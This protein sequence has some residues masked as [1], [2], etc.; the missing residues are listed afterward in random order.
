MPTPWLLSNS[1]IDPSLPSGYGTGAL[2][3]NVSS[4]PAWY[5][6]G[7]LLTAPTDT[8]ATS[9]LSATQRASMLMTTFGAVG[10][11]IGSFFAAE[12]QRNQLKMQ[13][14]NAKFASQMSAINARGSE[15]M[16]Q[17][18]INA[19]HQAIGRYTMQAGQA[20]ASAETALAGRGIELG[21]GSAKEVIGSMDLIKEIDRMTM[22][23]N[24]VRQ[25]EAYRMQAFNQRTQSVME[26]LT[27]RNLLT[28]A[29]GISSP[30]AGFSSLMGSGSTWWQTRL[31]G[32]ERQEMLDAMRAIRSRE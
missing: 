31:Q 22:S 4:L 14:Q 10:S 17:D 16:A 28:T 21:T 11:A 24:S 27:S 25:A 29:S 19:A 32:L 8:S 2:L 9:S 7:S 5:G 18:S 1:P 20:K 15:F 3:T 13:A 12:S 30:L 26:G 23:A 6:T